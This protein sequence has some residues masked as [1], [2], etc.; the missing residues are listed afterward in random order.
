MRYL[1]AITIAITAAMCVGCNS[2]ATRLVQPDTGSGKTMEALA[3]SGEAM[4]RHGRIDAH[5][6]VR[7]PDGV[8]IDV[9]SI[10]SR[11]EG[12]PTKGTV[13]VLHGLNESK[14]CFPYFGTGE[15]LAA[16]GFD[17]L[18]CDLRHHGRS[19]GEYV[20]YGARERND[21]KAVV[22]ELADPD[23]PV[24]VFGVNLGAMVAIQYASIDPRCEGVMAIA[25]YRDFR[26]YARLGMM[27]MPEIQFNAVIT[28]A[29]RIA[30]F[31]PDEASA[32]DA[33][34]NLPCQLLVVW[35][36]LDLSV[37]RQHCDDIYNA[38]PQP[39]QM[40]VPTVEN[41]ILISILEDWIA[42]RINQMATEGIQPS[43]EP[44]GNTEDTD[45]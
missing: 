8:I 14:A 7:T 25:P 10:R 12:E 32:V 40:I 36:V 37:P 6:R 4:V 11:L 20:T 15:R 26:S 34:A 21:I 45:G 3:G 5:D 33:A 16:L 29:G 28:D 42:D 23:L 39:K 43:D 41:I 35:N 17:V 13:V 19:T 31:N 27:M 30:N 24:Y 9:W 44:V 2:Y 18:L 22:D 38:A 1:L